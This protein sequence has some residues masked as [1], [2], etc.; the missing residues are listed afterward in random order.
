MIGFVYNKSLNAV[1]Q[2]CYL[3]YFKDL[4][5]KKDLIEQQIKD[6]HAQIKDLVPQHNYIVDFVVFDDG[7]IQI[8]ELNPF[9]RSTHSPFLLLILVLVS[10]YFCV[11]V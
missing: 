4:P 1:S 2:Y 11:L 6:F 8:V 9:V 10:R 3:Q 5:P 7:S